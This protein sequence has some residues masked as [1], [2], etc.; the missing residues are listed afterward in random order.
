MAMQ[1]TIL[2]VD[3]EG[4]TLFILRNPDAPF[5]VESSFT[6]WPR[7]LPQYW[8]PHMKENETSLWLSAIAATPATNNTPEIHMR[9]SS[10]HLTLAS[11]YFQ[12]L[13]SSGWIETK[14]ASGYSYTVT[15]K[16]WDADSLIILMNIIHGQTQKVPNKIDL[17]MLA[18]IAVLVDYYKCHKAV[19]FFADA[20]ISRLRQP[21]P[22]SYSRDLLLRLLVSY[23]FSEHRVFTALTKT[24]IYESRGPIHTLGLPIPEDMVYILEVERKQLISGLISSLN[25]LKTQLSKEEKECSFECSSMSLG[26][27]I[28][29]MISMRLD[30]PQPTDQFNGYSVVAIEKAIGDIKIPNYLGSLRH[31]SSFSGAT[32]STYTGGFGSINSYAEK[33]NCNLEKKIEPIVKQQLESLQGL[34]LASFPSH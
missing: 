17:E 20:W 7:A 22:S 27:L 2:E 13:A 32:H 15:A 24:I 26:A 9:L 19:R 25:S 12:K 14:V 21:L 1:P 31:G 11:V 16:D 33:P 30:D 3:P 29:G 23:I 4:D 28:K 18:K 10:K 34:S 8:M 5:A 6:L